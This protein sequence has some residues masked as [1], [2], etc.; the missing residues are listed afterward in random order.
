MVSWVYTNIDLGIIN[1][2][3]TKPAWSEMDSYYIGL[4]DLKILDLF[5][6]VLNSRG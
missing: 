2:W 4:L 5:Q 6:N 3:Y 1:S